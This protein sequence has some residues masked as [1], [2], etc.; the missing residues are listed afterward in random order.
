MKK[1]EIDYVLMVIIWL[2]LLRRSLMVT[3]QNQQN[4]DTDKSYIL[5]FERH[6]GAPKGKFDECSLEV[7]AKIQNYQVP[8]SW[9][10]FCSAKHSNLKLFMLTYCS[11]SCY[12]TLEKMV[13]LFLLFYS[14]TNSLRID[15]FA[16]FRSVSVSAQTCFRTHRVIAHQ[17]GTR[18]CSLIL[19]HERARNITIRF[20]HSCP[21]TLLKVCKYSGAYT[22]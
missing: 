5:Q 16:H 17:S 8:P 15:T 11:I 4:K 22:V 3:F 2:L 13:K 21:H 18:T 10:H 19:S 6:L 1:R 20:S 7:S 12:V 9:R 14:H